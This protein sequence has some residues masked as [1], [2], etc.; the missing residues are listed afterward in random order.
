VR[1]VYWAYF[2]TDCIPYT[3][4]A[5]LI[6]GFGTDYWRL[7]LKTW[8][9]TWLLTMMGQPT[10]PEDTRRTTETRNGKL[11]RPRLVSLDCYTFTSLPFERQPGQAVKQSKYNYKNNK[12]HVNHRYVKEFLRPQ[13]SILLYLFT[14]FSFFTWIL[15]CGW[16]SN[17]G[18]F[19]S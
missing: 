11:C 19:K 14:M 4:Y 3:G 16:N 18:M 2:L 7:K 6:S 5:H 1:K 13:A 8:R 15:Y 9:V 10:E 17:C 12:N